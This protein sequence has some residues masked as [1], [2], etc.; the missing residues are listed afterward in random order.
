[1]ALEPRWMFDGAAAVDAAHAAPDAAALALIPSV[2]A[3]VEV[4]AADPAKDN[5]R[6][7]VVFVD[8]SLADYKTLE[9]AVKEGVGIVEIDGGQSGLAQMAKW[10]ETHT[11]YDSIAILSHGAEGMVKIGT[12]IVTDAQLSDATTQA[13]LAEIG[14]ALKTG[15][16]LLLYGCDVAK[17]EDGQQLV[18]DLAAATGAD[19]AASD[20]VTGKSGDWTLE[21]GASG[22]VTPGVFAPGQLD[23]YLGDL[24]GGEIDSISWSSGFSFSA[25][26]SASGNNILLNLGG[27]LDYTTNGTFH[28]NSLDYKA[29]VYVN[30]YYQDNSGNIIASNVY[31]QKEV[32]FSAGGTQYYLGNASGLLQ[33][34]SNN[35]STSTSG[36]Y[37]ITNYS[38]SHWWQLNI[39]LSGTPYTQYSVTFNATPAFTGGSSQALSLTVDAS[40]VDLASTLHVSDTDSSQTETWTQ[41]SGPS[42]GSL[43]ISGATASSGSADITPGGTITYTPDAGYTGTD[44]FSIQVSDGTAT[45]TK[46]FTVT[47]NDAPTIS[48]ASAGQ[49]VNDTATVSPFTGVTIADTGTNQQTQTVSVTLD[50]A[51]KGSFT[52]LSGFTNAG[53]GV[54]TYSGTAAAATSA[55]RGLVFTPTANRVAPGSTETTTFTISTN[56]GIAS[57]V[58]N[59]TTTVVS[60]SL[61]DTPT[62]IALSS[63][64]VAENSAASTVVGSL[65]T[66]DADTGDSYT[67]TLV[68]GATD[69]FQIS[70][71]QLQVKSGANL[72]YETATSHSVT[73]R[74]TD[75]QGAFYDKAFTITVTN[76][77]ETPTDIALSAAS[78]PENSAGGTVV[79]NLS[80]TDPDSGNTFTY[81]LVGGATS[82][83][84]ISGSQLQVQAGANL[85]YETA[86]SHSVTVRVTDQGGLTYDKA[87]TITVTNVPDPPTVSINEG[88]TVTT[89]QSVTINA[90][91]LVAYDGEQA[92]GSLTYTI[93]TATAGGT[94]YRNGVALTTG[95]TFT[96]TDVNTGLITY[97]HG[98]GAGASDSFSFTVSDGVSGA[99]AS[100]SFAITVNR[101]PSGAIAATTWNGSGAKT[102]T[103]G[104]FS[105][106]DGDTLAYSAKLQDG[107]AMPSW[108]SLNSSTRTFSGNPPAGVSSLAV[109][110]TASD[111][112][113][114][115]GNADFTL[116][117]TN[118]ND[119]AT[120]A[121]AIPNQTWTGSG[122]KSYQVPATTFSADPDG[123]ALSYSATLQGGGALPAWLSFDA[124]SR[125]FSGN[126]PAGVGPFNLSVT[127]NDGNGG[128]VSSTFTLTLTTTNDAPVLV[129]PLSP[130]A[131]SGPGVWS[132]AVPPSTF[133]DADGDTLSWSATRAD[134]SA[135][136]A[137]LSFNAG[138]FTLS[139]NAPNNLP[140]V[141]VKVSVSDGQGGTASSSFR[142]NIDQNTS[143][144]APV[145]A[146]AIASQ[147]WTGSG[148]KTFQI[149]GNTFTD[150]DGDTLALSATLTGGGALPSWLSFN[151][152]RWSFSGNP[153][154]SAD[155]QTYAITV[156]AND[157]EG[158]TV[159]TAFNLTIASANDTPFLAAGI[160]DQTKSGSGAWSYQVPVGSFTD[161]DGDAITW[162]ATQGD[163]SALP[164]WLSFD[165]ATRT[166]SGNPPSSVSSL[167]LKVTGTDP[168]AASASSSFT[169]RVSDSNDAPV[170][171]NAVGPQYMT[172]PGAWSFQIPAN[173]FTDADGDTLS[174]SATQTDGSSLPSW[175]SFD[176]N[177]RTF[178]GNPP[179]GA[180]NVALK[181]AVSDGNGGTASTSFLLSIDQ[182]T[183]N[184]IPTV[185]NAIPAQSFD[186]AGNW[187][188]QVPG[189][190]FADGDGDQLSATATL[191]NGGALPSWM[192]FNA[193]TWTFSGNPPAS[194]NGQTYAVKVTAT[195]NQQGSVN[196]TFNLTVTNAND[197]PT[198][199]NGIAEQSWSGSAAKS[200]QFA[201]NTFADADGDTLTYSATKADG[202]ALPSWLSFNG[203]TRTFSGNPPS[204]LPY[205]DLKV[206]A[207]DGNGGTKST[208]FRQ[209]IGNANDTP[210][211]GS[212]GGSSLGS[213]GSYPIPFGTFSDPD[214]DTLTYTASGPNG[215]PLP[216][217]LKF[218]PATQTFSGTPP[219]GNKGS[220]PVT[221]TATDSSGAIISTLINVSYDS[222]SPPPPPPPPPPAPPPIVADT[223]KPP[224]PV[225][226]PTILSALRAA[227]ADGNA[228]TQGTSGPGANA[229]AAKIAAVTGGG[230]QVVVSNPPVNAISDGA[231]FVAK[232][233]P[234]VV[235]ESNV[236]N[237]AVPAD[238][239]GHTS[240]EAGIQLA[241]KMSDGRPL[242]PWMSFDATRGVFVGEAPEGFK[243]ALAV[244]VTARDNGGHEV[245][246]NFRIQIGGGAVKEGGREPPAADPPAPP[247]Q[248][249]RNG[250]QAPARD[251][252]LAFTQQLKQAGRH[253]A[254]AHFARWG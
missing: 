98:G 31:L 168:S 105:D 19:V 248:G 212:P 120:V 5:G 15:G 245:A 114:G 158:G 185:A 85:D 170:L 192:S 221:V 162:S 223:P 229:L 205:L 188:Y 231:L 53:G 82:K 159:S 191:S 60:T 90:T 236:I 6:K 9:A 177:T 226:A 27:W 37:V 122:A 154:A 119:T 69:K 213:G 144:D 28:N 76:V 233:I 59:A 214:G 129:T 109:R 21:Y 77:N 48:G 106:L 96:Q 147:T 67:Y 70:G 33:Y 161:A 241:A 134:G 12:D 68:G 217:W 203:A 123:D 110:V 116:T 1:M 197:T 184:D 141:D 111:G 10:A 88:A 51:A 227:V 103:F 32:S 138:T 38:I 254:V 22:P 62:D 94:L 251:G 187:I 49:A 181:V 166:F 143:N 25:S 238:A 50:T 30:G 151:P 167:T 210:V 124:A 56:D 171:A 93:G 35:F 209:L 136:P 128:T 44:T 104:A 133:S 99:T 40:T 95:S 73:V 46:T 219:V 246:T 84:Q 132:Y 193:S 97:T 34:S 190:T 117:I 252:K 81:S 61:N 195:D 196:T 202:T 13:E 54:Y 29:S 152:Q 157:N 74:T 11:G 211:V 169:L 204:S 174:W 165:A 125:T 66:T 45:A 247:P 146:N 164:S 242:P 207:S 83:F 225:D 208:T 215:A 91:R 142:L 180:P 183:T 179:W 71:S 176:A 4:R 112:K 148:S 89:G 240:A 182:S 2:T 149:P 87:F 80:A 163:G 160:P 42:H 153:P 137:W 230:F 186:G 101:N 222:P 115:T 234:A 23:A 178:T 26:A 243:G 86:T 201:A 7:E 118:A 14:H 140:Q 206:T 52:T 18:N 150:A 127:A 17:G 250:A 108:L 218:D 139:G 47:V 39:G 24:A 239:F 113:G 107:S 220:V 36:K 8:T 237:F 253:A 232:G 41:S 78:V 126:P 189:N 16:D 58:T 100:T 55:V 145:A 63:S 199:A 64:S 72:D 131:M 175:L 172:G 173:T 92:A 200:F 65:T 135:L 79:G 20:D 156:S 244:V 130:Q 249:Q 75:S 3:P 235:M 216:S 224:P 198:V 102:Y 155:G 228:F 43:S 57:A 121:N 194:A